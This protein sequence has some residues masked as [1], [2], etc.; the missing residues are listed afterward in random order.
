MKKWTRREF[1]PLVGA[2]L[3]TGSLLAINNSNNEVP[4]ELNIEP[5]R[6]HPKK[7]QAGDTIGLCASAGA[8]RREAEISEFSTIL[9]EM[10]FKVKVGPNVLKKHGYFAGTDE[11]RA[12]DFMDFIEDTEVNAIFFLRG[13]WGTARLINLLD[14]S[15]IK[16]NPKIIM[17]FSDVTTLLNSI[18]KTCNLVT[19]HGPSGNSSWNAYTRD[20]IKR[21]LVNGELVTYKNKKGDESIT[22]YSPGT[23]TGTLLGGNLSVVT[24]LIGT[25]QEPNWMGSILFLE[26]VM[27]E[28]YSIDR[29]LTHLKNAQVLEKV[30]G[31]ILGNFRKCFAEEPNRSFTLE[32]VFLQHFS[33]CG[34]PVYYG[35]QIGHTVNKYTIPVGVKATMDAEVGTLQLLEAAVS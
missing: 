31:V 1:I 12:S 28:P 22:T 23:A 11:E 9:Q 4:G 3:A 27:E 35:A 17:G 14:Y 32:E 18:S 25:P 29:M 8:L 26:D 19:F 7:L 6:Q 21:V 10:G 34:K 24:T 13:G 16:D 5:R 2:G 30:N 20:Y 15:K 33:N